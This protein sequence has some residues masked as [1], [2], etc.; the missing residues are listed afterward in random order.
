MLIY[1]LS[2]TESRT[3]FLEKLERAR[4]SVR[5]DSPLPIL[6]KPGSTSINVGNW[7]LISKK[8]G[9]LRIVNTDGQQ[10]STLSNDKK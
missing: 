8:D 3:E 10:V 9:E 6:S 5:S 7:C 4:S 2:I 1:R